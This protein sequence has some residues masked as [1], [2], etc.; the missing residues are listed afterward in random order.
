[1]KHLLARENLSLVEQMAWS[2]VLLAFD[3]DGTLSPIV[4]ERQGAAMRERTRKLFRRVCELYPCAVV[5]GRARSDV[6]ARLDGA[7]V[8]Y[9]V[10][11][12]GLEPGASLVRFRREIRGVRPLLTQQLA[13]EQG[14]DVEDK[15]YS[16]AVHYRRSRRKRAAR[17]AILR[18]VGGLPGAF[19]V[20]PGKCV[21]NVLPV[22][23]PH[24]GDAVLKLRAAARADTVL[25]V[26]DDVTDEDVFQ[27]DQPGRL[28]NVR[29]GRSR[30]SAAAYFLRDQREVDAL[31]ATLCSL[32]ERRAA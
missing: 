8:R 31:L 9:V 15:E 7:R 4:A 18:A 19:R 13:A 21:I 25:Y 30:A 2:Q 14:V 17:T 16:L 20:V 27:I 10:G 22:Q 32:R 26:G 11:N 28:L 1:M 24:K 5:S 12:H 3:F 23:A 6:R 29:V